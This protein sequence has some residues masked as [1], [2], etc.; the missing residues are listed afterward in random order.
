[1]TQVLAWLKLSAHF[2]I[3]EACGDAYFCLANTDSGVILKRTHDYYYQVTGH[4]AFTSSQNWHIFTI[5]MPW[6]RNFRVSM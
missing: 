3:E 1:M 6:V 5:Y 4:L 2:T